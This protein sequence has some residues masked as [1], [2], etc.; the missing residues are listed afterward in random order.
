MWLARWE[1]GRARAWQLA[2]ERMPHRSGGPAIGF[3]SRD[4]AAHSELDASFSAKAA[5]SGERLGTLREG[6]R[7][8]G[9]PVPAPTGVGQ[10]PGSHEGGPMNW[11]E[12]DQGSNSQGEAAASRPR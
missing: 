7:G 11:S 12:S 1:H 4:P 3:F 6:R 5:F 9:G 10:R 8:V 2:E